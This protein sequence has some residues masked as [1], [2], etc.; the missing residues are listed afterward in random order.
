MIQ[1]KRN[2]K[3]ICLGKYF[4]FCYNFLFGSIGKPLEITL[5]ILFNILKH[6]FVK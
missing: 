5:V 3:I 1:K 6:M 2:Q 4:L